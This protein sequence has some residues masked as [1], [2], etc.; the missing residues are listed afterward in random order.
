MLQ[1]E[2][3]LAIGRFYLVSVTG[4]YLFSLSSPDIPDALISV[5]LTGGVSMASSIPH[6]TY[7][8]AGP[9]SKWRQQ[10]SGIICAATVISHVWF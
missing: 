5:Y 2:E 9:A 8:L 6:Q 3:I 4:L 10:E 1:G 7:M